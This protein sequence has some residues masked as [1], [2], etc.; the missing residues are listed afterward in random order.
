MKSWDIE[1]ALAWAYRE[2]LPKLVEGDGT[3]GGVRSAWSGVST[4]ARLLT[5][6]DDNRYGV[7][8]NLA[9]RG[10]PHPDALVIGDAVNALEAHC[11]GPFEP[12]EGWDPFEDFDLGEDGPAFARRGLDRLTALDRDGEGRSIR[13]LKETPGRLVLKHAILGGAPDWASEPPERRWLVG[14]NG[15]PTWFRKVVQHVT[16]ATGSVK[17]IE[18]EEHVADPRRVK[19]AYRKA[20]YEPD[21]AEIAR[22]RAE[23]ELWRAALDAVAE[24]LDGALTSMA[25][26]PSTR[27]RR[28]WTE[29]QGDGPRVLRDFAQGP[30]CLGERVFGGKRWRIVQLMP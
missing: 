10:E 13:R 4:Y 25:V 22:E 16:T 14:A 6:I 12:P 11:A 27:P 5:V 3:I 19:G 23:Y 18:H 2:E 29:P 17:A 9:E 26:R 21:P 1:R 20:V 7:V 30:V 28:P 8:P 24:A 15:K